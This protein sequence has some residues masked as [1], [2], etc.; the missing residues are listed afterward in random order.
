MPSKFPSTQIWA[1]MSEKLGCDIPTI[2][3]V[4][5]VEAAG[6]FY[7]TNGSMVR[8]FEP[9]HFPKQYWGELRFSTGKLAAWRAALKVP[10]SMR[11]RMFDVAES[12]D[13]ESAYDASSWGAP[14]MMGF[15][16]EVCGYS[17][18]VEMV[19]AFE[20]SADEQVR[21]F[22]AFVI[23]NNLDTHLRSHNW[24]AFAAGYNG[25]GKAAAYGAKIESAYRRQSGG[26][27]SSPMLSMGRKGAPV[28]ELQQ[29][30]SALG[31]DVSVDGHYGAGT[32]RAVRAFQ[33]ANGLKV[34]GVAGAATIRELAQLQEGDVQEI[35]AP[36]A[37]RAATIADLRVDT[38]V[39]HGTSVLGFG[40]VG[41]LMSNLSENSQTI[42][43]GGVVVGAIILAALFLMKKRI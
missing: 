35:E 12:I 2:K 11:R 6:K 18:A 3:A 9:H 17:S 31:Y 32:R 13:A 33:G 21:A 28:I 37:E 1:E 30:L 29:Q 27:R 43:I 8:R 19:A 22:V 41:G 39:K 7:N 10:T 42:L 25:S 26:R 38:I 24:V 36:V 20:Q 16:A 14:Q 4:F 40:G 23:S 34:D 5:E 15:N